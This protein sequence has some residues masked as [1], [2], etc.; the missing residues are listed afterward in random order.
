MLMR[1]L[2]TGRV[3][4]VAALVSASTA[5][6]LALPAFAGTTAPAVGHAEVSAA[7]VVATAGSTPAA[8]AVVR[9]S[10]VALGPAVK[11]VREPDGTVRR[12][13]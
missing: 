11:Y 10:G 2:T 9:T 6:A 1:V 13:R 4:G 3:L 7:T 12:V 8:A 5:A